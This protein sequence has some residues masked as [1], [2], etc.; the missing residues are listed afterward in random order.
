MEAKN[1]FNDEIM[2]TFQK[3]LKDAEQ[4]RERRTYAGNYLCK[5]QQI[6]SLNERNQIDLSQKNAKDDQGDADYQY[7]DDFVDEKDQSSIDPQ[8][9]LDEFEAKLN[10]AQKRANKE[11]EARMLKA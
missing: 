11:K 5:T 7:E 10:K 8:E 1:T 3:E 9:K 2:I 4:R 6:S